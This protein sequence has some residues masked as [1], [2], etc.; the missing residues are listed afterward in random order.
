MFA[1]MLTVQYVHVHTDAVRTFPERI[2][3]LWNVGWEVEG[4]TKLPQAR[5]RW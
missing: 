2:L 1:G 5:R 3:F 4:I